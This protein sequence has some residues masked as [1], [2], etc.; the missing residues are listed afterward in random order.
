MMTKDLALIFHGENLKPD[1]Y[2]T[3]EQ[4]L[5]AIDNTL[6]EKYILH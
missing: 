5:S 2:L 4:F 6:R 1:H 3:T